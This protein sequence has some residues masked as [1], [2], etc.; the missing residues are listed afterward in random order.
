MLGAHANA[1]PTML[2][3]IA[4]VLPDSQ[5][6]CE[7]V[8]RATYTIGVGNT[9]VPRTAASEGIYSSNC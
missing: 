8:H 6:C 7:S 4:L 5:Q 3:I 1:G 2:G 9:R